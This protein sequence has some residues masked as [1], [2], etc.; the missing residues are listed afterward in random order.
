LINANP[1]VE[2]T[3]N[4]PNKWKITGIVDKF[5]DYHTDIA[6]P[7]LSINVFDGNAN[8]SEGGYANKGSKRYELRN[9]KQCACCRMAGHNIGD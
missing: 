9:K 2:K 6:I 3:D 5:S 7:S 8:I 1:A 4:L